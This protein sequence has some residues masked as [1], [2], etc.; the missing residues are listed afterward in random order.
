MVRKALCIVLVA[1][2]AYLVPRSVM[3]DAEPPPLPGPMPIVPGDQSP[4]VGPLQ[5]G[6]PAFPNGLPPATTD[7]RGVGV[8][9]NAALG[10]PDAQLPNSRPGP[11]AQYPTGVVGSP[12]GIVAGTLA[13]LDPGA[14]PAGIPPVPLGSL[15]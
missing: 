3:A 13:A 5:F 10:G 14:A 8:G 2:A 4:P 11:G 6:P 15:P 9:T 12:G 1:G 7:A